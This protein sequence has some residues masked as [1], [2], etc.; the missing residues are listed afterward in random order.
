MKTMTRRA[1]K[2]VRPGDGRPLPRFRWWHMPA[3]RAVFYLTVPG[4]DGHRPRY[5]VEVWRMGNVKDGKVTASLYRD[6]RRVAMSALPA[7]FPVGNGAIEVSAS[8]VGLKR[9]R[10]VIPGAPPRPLTPHPRSA[11]GRRARLET[12]HPSLSRGIAGASLLAL[13]AGLGLNLVQLAE[14]VTETP[15]VAARVGSFDSPVHLPI[16]LNILLGF[17]P[18]LASAERAMRL[19][20][21]W[22]DVGGR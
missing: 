4:T 20:Y 3:G 14:I 8:N 17:G 5:D 10:Y 18:V 15:A 22:L 13:V 19:R 16:W 6:G 11:E 12:T 9:C 21:G 7:A 1:G 2:R